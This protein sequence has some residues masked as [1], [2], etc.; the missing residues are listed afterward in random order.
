MRT[1]NHEQIPLTLGTEQLPSSRNRLAVIVGAA[2]TTAQNDISVVVTLSGRN[3]IQP[4]LRGSNKVMRGAHRLERVD[5]RSDSTISGI[6]KPHRERQ[7]RG[8]FTVKLRLGGTSPHGAD[9]DQVGR[10]LWGNGVEHLT[11]NREPHVCD[12]NQQLSRQLDT[13]IDVVRVVNVR[14]VDQAFPAH[15]GPGLLEVGPHDD[16]QIVA[17]LL[18]QLPQV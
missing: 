16:T 15:G 17:E 18:G 6:L 2:S 11:C 3:S 10:V 1:V 14:V 12:I 5:S 7:A 9:T 13:L 4:L 8:Q